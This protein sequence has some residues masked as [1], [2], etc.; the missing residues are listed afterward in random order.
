MSNEV[1]NA[2]FSLTE[3][4]LAVGTLGI[5]MLFIAGT[6]L[7]GIHFSTI[8]AEQTTAAVA[9]D[10]AF[11]KIRLYGVNLSGL[12][13]DQLKPFE[14]LRS[15]DPNEFAYPSTNIDASQKQYYWSALCRRVDSSQAARLVQVTIFVTRKA[16]SAA[17]YRGVKG[18][19][20][21]MQVAISRAAGS[22]SLTITEADKITWVNDGY[23]IV[24]NKTGRIYRVLKRDA[25]QPNL[26]TL[27]RPWQGEQTGSVWVVPPPIG[28]GRNP[29]IAIY[30]KVMRL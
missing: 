18:W 28:G 16:G 6:F 15:I 7:T 14:P 29:T 17:S 4:L 9:A 23:T 21:P 3:V 1:K 26:V 25:E 20:I 5:G 30:Q 27:D 11:A 2:G 12:T 10:E 19:P 24:D 22:N 13:A 8:S